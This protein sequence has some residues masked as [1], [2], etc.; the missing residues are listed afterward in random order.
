MCTHTFEKCISVAGAA[1]AASLDGTTSQFSFCSITLRFQSAE[2]KSGVW[3]KWLCKAKP[4]QP[5]P[6]LLLWGTQGMEN[7]EKPTESAAL[8][9]G[10]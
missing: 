3:E 2:I 1:V 7:R 4:L 10:E 6:L 5:S 9:R 8:A